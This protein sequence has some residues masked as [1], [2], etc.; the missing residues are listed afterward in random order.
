MILTIVAVIAEMT[1]VWFSVTIAHQQQ[2][3]R[4]TGRNTI[5][6]YARNCEVVFGGRISCLIH[7]N[8]GKLTRNIA[9]QIAPGMR[10]GNAIPLAISLGTPYCTNNR[11]IARAHHIE[12][13][14]EPK[15]ATPAQGRRTSLCPIDKTV[16]CIDK[17]VLWVILS[18]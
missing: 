3:M 5:T 18:K 10:N 16:F 6:K 13:Y 2:L 7:Q 15:S 14:M 1:D 9:S 12:K 4:I 8:T 17:L 11:Q